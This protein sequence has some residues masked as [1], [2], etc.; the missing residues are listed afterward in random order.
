MRR[1]LL[2]AAAGRTANSPRAVP[3]T[4]LIRS[5][6]C[7]GFRFGWNR[8]PRCRTSTAPALTP[9]RPQGETLR[10][11]D[12]GVPAPG[13]VRRG[14]GALHARG[15]GL[16]PARHRGAAAAD[17]RGGRL[18]RAPRRPAGGN[19]LGI[20]PARGASHPEHGG[21]PGRPGARRRPGAP[22]RGGAVRTRPRARPRLPEDDALPAV[23]H[24]ALLPL[25]LHP[26]GGRRAGPAR[27]P[28]VRDGEVPQRSPRR[29]P[30]SA[31]APGVD[32]FSPASSGDFFRYRGW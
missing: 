26:P 1:N 10:R 21:A 20:R 7:A 28:A 17:G 16:H 24:R 19:R 13:R 15:A 14:G 11:A 30:T 29:P 8:P 12:R 5:V 22:G 25:G 18:A 23:G 31:S 27:G 32:A 9:V 2:T 4:A 3:A 6:S